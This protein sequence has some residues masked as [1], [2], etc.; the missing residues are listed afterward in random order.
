MYVYL[1]RSQ[2]DSTRRYVGSTLDLRKRLA[3]H[4]DQA[5]PSTRAHIPW[6]LVVAIWFNDEVK[7]QRFE[8]YLKQGAGHAF[9]GRHFW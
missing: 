4:N 7:A 9:A 5:S 6:R 3:E 8:Q 2:S 1:I